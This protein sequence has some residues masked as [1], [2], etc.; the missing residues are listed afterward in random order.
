MGISFEDW[1]NRIANRSDLTGR[2]THLTK[3]KGLNFTEMTFEEINLKA[4]DN[5]IR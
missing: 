5:L 3:P 1:K 2:L 4:V